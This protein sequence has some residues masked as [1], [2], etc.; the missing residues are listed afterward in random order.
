MQKR[1]NRHNHRM[2]MQ[3]QPLHSPFKVQIIGHLLTANSCIEALR[4]ACAASAAIQ[5]Q[6]ADPY[7]YGP[8]APTSSSAAAGQAAKTTTTSTS[9][10]SNQPNYWAK[11][12]G[13]GSGTTQQQWNVNQH[14]AKRKQ[15]EENV[16]CVLNVSF[17]NLIF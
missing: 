8:T 9:H 2:K 7:G 4:E 10:Q 13:F 14:I 17:H 1:H 6:S 3:Y 12:T 16:A 11:G 5:R 15:D